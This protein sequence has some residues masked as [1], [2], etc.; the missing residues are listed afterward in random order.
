MITQTNPLLSVLMTA[1]NREKYIA[2]AIES[3]LASTFTNFELIIVDDCSDDDTVKIA[4]H[5]EDQDKRVKVYVNEKNLGQFPNRNHAVDFAHGEYVMYVDSDDKIFPDGFERL[6]SVMNAYPESSFGLFSPSSHEVK[7]LKSEEAIASHFFKSPLLVCGPGGTILRREF[8]NRIGRYPVD[9]G[10]PGDMYFNLKVCCYS[11]IVLVPFEF[12]YY[13]RHE[14][15]EINNFYDYLYNN[16]KYMR[17]ALVK[18]PLPITSEQKDWLDK[19]NKRR[20]VM[21]ILKY[22]FKTHNYR[23]TK[24][25]IEKAGFSLRDAIGGVFH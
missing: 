3:V 19:K 7:V 12:M 25:A 5:Y 2:E 10:I 8:V 15:Q 21:S 11:S 17:D 24:I 4:R 16:Y 23:K 9:Y 20:F 1:Y 22:F 13:R 14:G 18:L 6:I